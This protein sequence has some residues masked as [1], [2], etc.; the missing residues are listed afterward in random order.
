MTESNDVIE[1]RHLLLRP[2]FQVGQRVRVNLKGHPMHAR[3]GEVVGLDRYG[4]WHI[5]FP[6]PKP[7]YRA[8]R[9]SSLE[10]LTEGFSAVGFRQFPKKYKDDFASGFDASC[11]SVR[12]WIAKRVEETIHDTDTFSRSAAS[13]RRNAAIIR[14]RARLDLLRQ[15]WENLHFDH[16]GGVQGDDTRPWPKEW[17]LP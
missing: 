8:F 15:L 2:I 12:V 3:E 1:P 16:I 14:Q 11:E 7:G 13:P 6:Y 4:F 10:P 9:P 5:D 17:K